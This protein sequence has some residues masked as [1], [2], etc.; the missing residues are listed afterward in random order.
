MRGKLT[1]E[2]RRIAIV[3]ALLLSSG[4]IYLSLNFSIAPL[5]IVGIPAICAYWLWYV[6]YL[7]RP[8]DPALILPAFLLSVGGFALHAVEE[9]LGHYGP[10]V[11]R[12]FGFAWSDAAFIVIVLCL[13]GALSVAAVGLQRKIPIA[14]LIA[15]VFMTTRLAEALL[16]V[17]PLLSPAMQ[18]DNTATI[19]RSVNGTWVQ[20]MPNYYV[21]TV[22]TYYWP[23]MYTVILPVLPAVI[24]LVLIW[25]HR[26]KSRH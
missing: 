12:L 21:Q 26:A 17:F 5:F 19:S 7:K 1:S 10:A 22:G 4:T 9:Y 14:G 20:D 25:R 16:F 3:A 23:G 8:I 2:Q 18:P 11:G 6:A 24:G 15:I 13:L